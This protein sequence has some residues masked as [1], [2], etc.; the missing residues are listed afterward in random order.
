L[1]AQRAQC[2]EAIV[3]D[4]VDWLRVVSDSYGMGR[5]E[6]AL[7]EIERLREALNS[8]TKVPRSEAAE[9]RVAVL[10]KELEHYATLF[11]EQPNEHG[12]GKFPADH[13][14]GCKAR[15]ALT[16]EGI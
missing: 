5:C 1:C 10:E 15:A 7:E 13:C 8:I 11:C 2:W 6:E 3:S 14:S 16:P 12:C 9:A 4:I